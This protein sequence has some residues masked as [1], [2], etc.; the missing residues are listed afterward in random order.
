MLDR[1]STNILPFAPRPFCVVG[2]LLQRFPDLQHV[3]PDFGH[4]DAKTE[5]ADR[6]DARA[7]P[8]CGG[9]D[10]SGGKGDKPAPTRADKCGDDAYASQKAKDSSHNNSSDDVAPNVACG[11]DCR[12][13]E[14]RAIA[15]GGAHIADRP[16]L[17]LIAW[18]TLKAARGQRVNQLQLIRM[19]RAGRRATV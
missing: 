8:D 5:K 1:P 10:V 13:E 7:K 4:G 17:R 14:A 6:A 3:G 12:N 18:A 16:G 9:H 2:R 19:Q 11:F 15:L